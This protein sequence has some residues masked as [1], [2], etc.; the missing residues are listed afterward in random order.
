MKFYANNRWTIAMSSGVHAFGQYSQ[1]RRIACNEKASR[2]EEICGRWMCA[3]YSSVR[4]TAGKVLRHEWVIRN[5]HAAAIPTIHRSAGSAAFSARQF[6]NK[7][8]KIPR[9]QW[10]DRTQF[11]TIDYV[12]FVK[13]CGLKTVT[14]QTE[15]NNYCLFCAQQHTRFA[16]SS[17]YN[18]T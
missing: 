2:K 9:Y 17:M 6:R 3:G 7:T 4:L 14:F 18:W 13:N 8:A 12:T 16:C 11:T 1:V 10:L 15:R 5:G